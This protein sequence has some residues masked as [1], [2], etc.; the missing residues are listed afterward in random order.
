MELH[1][2]GESG[3]RALAPGEPSPLGGSET[4][5]RRVLRDEGDHVSSMHS[6]SIPET[7]IRLR[8]ACFN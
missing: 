3:D 7:G 5:P 4:L 2:P 1:D 6:S 8:H